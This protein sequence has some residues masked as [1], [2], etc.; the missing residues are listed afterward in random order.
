MAV[1]K[2]KPTGSGKSG[3]GKKRVTFAIEA[4]GA[5]EVFVCGSFNDWDGR[6]PMKNDGNGAWKAI[7][8]LAPGTYEYRIKVDGHWVDDPAAQAHVPNPFGSRNCVRTV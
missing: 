5:K 1:E 8:M 2:A 6:T 3:A 7:V 4:P